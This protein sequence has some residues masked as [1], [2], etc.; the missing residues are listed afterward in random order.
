M[1]ITSILITFFY[2]SYCQVSEVWHK[3]YNGQGDYSDVYTCTASD[4]SG[5]IYVGGY[6]MSIGENAN[7]L[8]A[9]YNA[10]G[11]LLWHKTWN[12]TGNG[13]D[14]ANKIKFVN[15]RI[16]ATGYVNSSVVGH[17][18]FTI[19]LTQDGDS[20][21]ANT[22]NDNTYNQY[23]I[24]ND[25]I[26]TSNGHVVVTGQSDSDPTN[27]NNDDYLTISYDQNGLQ[28]WVKRFNGA[29]NGID[30][31]TALCADNL[32]NVYITGRSDNGNDDDYV[33]IKYS[34]TG[35]LLWTMIFDNGGNDRAEDIDIDASSNVYIVG[36][37][38][39][40]NNNDITTV[41]YSSGGVQQFAVN[42][43]Y[44]ED[45]R[46][47]LIN[48]A[49]NGTF[50]VAGRSD[51]AVGAS[52]NYNIS[53]IRYASNGTITWESNYDNPI[54]TDD[55]VTD[56][57]LLSDG[58]TLV[59]G[60]SAQSASTPNIF[61][62][63]AR[64]VTSTGNLGWT[65]TYQGNPNY[66]DQIFGCTETADGRIHLCG[67]IENADARGN[68]VLIN[69]EQ[70][71]SLQSSLI[72]DGRGDNSDNIRK[73]IS[74][75]LGNLYVAAYQVM[76]NNDRDISLLKIN[77]IGDTLWTRKISGTLNGSDDDATGLVLDN[78]NNVYISGF[79]KNSG[80][81]SDIVLNK[82][83]SNGMLQWQAL[84][85]SPF[86]ES[87]RCYDMTIDAEGNIILTGKVDIN[88]S[89][90]ILNDEI[91]TIKYNSSGTQLWASTYTGTAGL[92]RG[93]FVRT[94]PDNKIDVI[95]WVAS[96]THDDLVVIQYDASGNELWHNTILDID[97]GN[98]NPKDAFV[99]LNGKLYITG[100]IEN[101][102][103]PSLQKGFAVCYL[104]DGTQ[105]WI[106][107][108]GTDSGYKD[109][110]RL[111]PLL[112]TDD[113][114]L[115][116]TTSSDTINFNPYVARISRSDGTIIWESTLIG[117]NN[118]KH[119]T[120]DAAISSDEKI[121]VISH[122]DS[123]ISAIEHLKSAISIMDINN[124]NSLSSTMVSYSDSFTVF[125]RVLIDNTTLIA[126]GSLW[127][128]EGQRDLVIGKWDIPAGIRNTAVQS[129]IDIYPNPT[130]ES[131]FCQ[132]SSD[133]I[134]KTLRIINI[135]GQTVGEY[136]INSQMMKFSITDLYNGLYF[137][138]L[139]QSDHT[140]SKSFIKQ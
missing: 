48:V 15:N 25:L 74:D 22:Y 57:V 58:G 92:D 62:L 117:L 96:G 118:N 47:D 21:W 106:K 82:Y 113:A 65:Y 104:N 1:L 79:V 64:K 2:L 97:N 119:I 4:N 86:S 33:T 120:D 81:S 37:S 121:Y 53:I 14:R 125:N 17:D 73:M 30:R 31:A 131:L 5:N 134:G 6:T 102:I 18:F 19:S 61:N 72:L 85:N 87:D 55:Y 13:P 126:G 78:Q 10:S 100:I 133:C 140:I 51:Y 12:G 94:T 35:S 80:S 68:A 99:D 41:K 112:N 29:S 40:G 52:L 122:Y 44:I 20:I 71:G 16:Y 135:N 32:N 124:G 109:F 75:N 83:N 23:D 39:N 88:N 84:Y 63:F 59:C 138:E 76:K 136:I 108:F 43:D 9:K 95:G 70:N 89:P 105:N 67:T 90:T 11:D 123:D 137:I 129:D 45:D 7:F 127:S 24:A 56:L 116:G 115:V 46:G 34:S 42:Y 103:N 128:N 101:T 77:S 130:S 54:Q 3:T 8:V 132:L 36:R 49:D 38:N 111:L 91:I 27:L 98:F 66:N 60:Y 107:Y 114:I 110:E 69:L 50:T 26:I 28:L 93:K 139:L